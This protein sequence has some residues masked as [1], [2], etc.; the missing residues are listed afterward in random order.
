MLKTDK[1]AFCVAFRCVQ[2]PKVGQN[3][4]CFTGEKNTPQTG[5]KPVIVS[6]ERK[7]K[8]YKRKNNGQKGKTNILF[9]SFQVHA[10]TQKLVGINNIYLCYVEV[11]N[12]FLGWSAPMPSYCKA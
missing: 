3:V 1:K 8:D 2:L 12:T 6:S 7:K 5:F 9:A 11:F 4:V 10:P